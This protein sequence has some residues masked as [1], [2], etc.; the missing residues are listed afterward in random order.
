MYAIVGDKFQLTTTMDSLTDLNDAE[1]HASLTKEASI[2]EQVTRVTR[3]NKSHNVMC[4]IW[5]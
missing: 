3:S 1:N 5:G 4:K 2:K